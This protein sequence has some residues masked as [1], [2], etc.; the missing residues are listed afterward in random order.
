MA[1]NN[2]DEL[3]MEQQRNI[4]KE[5]C[6]GDSWTKA[7]RE[8]Q[9]NDL[10]VSI[11]VLFIAPELFLQSYFSEKGLYQLRGISLVTALTRTSAVITWY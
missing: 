5:V 2:Q 8:T 7:E 3:I 1:N 10:F 4:E 9:T 11:I 6:R